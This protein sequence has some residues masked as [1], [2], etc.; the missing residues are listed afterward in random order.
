MSAAR[1]AVVGAVGEAAG[2][3]LRLIRC[4]NASCAEARA[5]CLASPPC[6]TVEVRPA[7]RRARGAAAPPPPP[8]ATLRASFASFGS[9]V[10][11][12]LREE[13]LLCRSLAAWARSGAV[14]PGAYAARH[15]RLLWRDHFCDEYAAPRGEAL[16][17]LGAA[18][19]PAPPAPAHC[20]PREA[21]LLVFTYHNRPSAWLC[22]FLRS[23]AFRG[24]PALVL[25]WQPHAFARA[26]NVFYF[27]DRVYT[28]LRYLR[29]CGSIGAEAKLIFC[30]ADEML[31][32]GAAPLRRRAEELLARTGAQVVLSAEARCM[33]EK[34]GKLAWAHSVA[35][36]GAMH[37]K[38]PRC[39]NTGNWIGRAKPVAAM[40]HRICRPCQAGL[41]IDAVSRRYSRAYSAQVREWVYSEQAELM[42]LYLAKPP[43]ESGW[44]LDF[45]QRLFHPNFWFNPQ[46]DTRVLP[47]GRIKNVHTGS[48][49]AF[50]HYNGNS[51]AMW[52]GPHA[53]AALS[54][55]LR[56]AYEKRTGDTGLHKLDAFL[57]DH[58]AFLGPTFQRDTNVTFADVCR[59]GAI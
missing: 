7:G 2:R 35:S 5:A 10:D 50:I 17:D 42:R 37:K 59:G 57:R 14:P 32:L 13:A 26:N 24:V 33:P 20:P 36:G 38:W 44:T 25:G 55:A 58:V 23:L 22:A 48:L 18:L 28:Y 19:P 51:K 39:L 43:N 12:L 47:D 46:A 41:D 56:R 30:D 3:P 34:L 21:E 29:A 49:P 52:T 16:P 6:D 40:L 9:R 4:A 8:T 31:Q 54:A 11:P 53:P 45:Q 1:L 27:T 15:R